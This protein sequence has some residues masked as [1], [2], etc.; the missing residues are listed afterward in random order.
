M[1][2]GLAQAGKG[3]TAGQEGTAPMAVPART[4]EAMERSARRV[5]V[6]AWVGTA[7]ASA[8]LAH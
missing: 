1:A 3:E 8:A 6:V 4:T 5:A 7:A 2:I